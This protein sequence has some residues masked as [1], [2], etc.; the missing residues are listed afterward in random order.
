MRVLAVWALLFAA[1]HATASG[2]DATEFMLSDLEA[3]LQ[4]LEAEAGGIEEAPRELVD[5]LE[6]IREE[7][8]YLRVKMRKHVETGRSGTGVSD[9]EV[10]TLTE[11]IASLRRELRQ[12]DPDRASGT[13]ALPEGT[14][15]S[16]RLMDTLTTETAQ[17]GDRFVASLVEPATR[18][19]AL[20]LP[21]G[22][23][24]HGVVELVDRA[25]GGTD[26]KAR[27][28][29]AFER[30]EVDGRSLP[31]EATVID[32]SGDL[33]TGIGD[34]K[35]KVGI[36]AGLGTILGAVVGGKKGA[37]VGAV[38]GGAGAILATE[39]AE[40]LLEHGAILRI[41][42]DREVRIESEDL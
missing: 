9:D 37:V 42:L 22:A 32:A 15:V 13:S 34:E 35:E 2:D 36:A 11:E 16:V 23:R 21:A 5:R 7:A 30:V 27:L 33:E 18:L 24:F 29:L 1:L 31:L 12:L 25:E 28:V 3:G 6:R 14:E 39:G 26:R 41:R 38:L 19:G 8:T 10:R 40:V 4:N 20:V 17:V